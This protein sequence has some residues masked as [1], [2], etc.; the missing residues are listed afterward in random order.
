MN[1]MT[2]SAVRLVNCCRSCSESTSTNSG[3]GAPSVAARTF[4]TFS[5]KSQQI[6]RQPAMYQFSLAELYRGQHQ[7]LAI[8]VLDSTVL[9]AVNSRCVC[10]MCIA[11]AT[12]VSYVQSVGMLCYTY[13]PINQSIN[14]PIQSIYAVSQLVNHIFNVRSKDERI[15]LCLYERDQEHKMAKK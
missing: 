12:A 7:Y 4:L 14:Q 15:G 1:L 5:S 11:A 9:F 10:I 2:S 3:G 13:Y 6:Q 8:T